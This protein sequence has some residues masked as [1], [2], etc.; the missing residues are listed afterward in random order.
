V[1]NTRNINKGD[2]IFYLGMID[3]SFGE[4]KP[5]Y[6]VLD[7][8]D[9][10][11]YKRF[12]GVFLVISGSLSEKEQFILNELYGVNEKRKTLKAIGEMLNIGPER[13][14]Q[15]AKKAEFKMRSILKKR[16]NY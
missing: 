15:I 4:V 11:E 5:Y 12:I 14:R 2:A 9:S 1:N 13:V 7:E 8:R 6:K 10:D 16:I 3:S